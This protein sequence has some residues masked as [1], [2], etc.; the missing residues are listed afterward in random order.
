MKSPI[1]TLILITFICATGVLLA[2]PAIAVQTEELVPASAITVTTSSTFDKMQDA[3]H[4]VDGSGLSGDRLDNAGGAQTMWHTTF[5]LEQGDI[6][7]FRYAIPRTGATIRSS[8]T[9]LASNKT[10]RP[11]SYL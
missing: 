11:S 7:P 5:P 10:A 8:P 2:S 6:I 3:R 1:T 9:G 4:L